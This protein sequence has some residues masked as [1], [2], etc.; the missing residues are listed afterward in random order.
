MTSSGG[1][2]SSDERDFWFFPFMVVCYVIVFLAWTCLEPREDPP[3]R[4]PAHVEAHP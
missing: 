2:P 1:Q 4:D 3:P